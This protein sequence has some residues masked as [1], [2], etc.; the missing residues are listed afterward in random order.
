MWLR[1]GNRVR[2]SWEEL[3]LRQWRQGARGEVGWSS[4]QRQ[5]ALRLEDVEGRSRR[6]REYVCESFC[7]SAAWAFGILRTHPEFTLEAAFRPERL[8][9]FAELRRHRQGVFPI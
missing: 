1:L 4:E 3:L 6:W 2:R 7:D 8:R 9:W 5:R